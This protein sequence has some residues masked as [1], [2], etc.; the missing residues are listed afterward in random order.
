MLLIWPF[1]VLR[2]H[3]QILVWPK[4]KQPGH[5]KTQPGHR[6]TQPG[7]RKT[8]PGV[9]FALAQLCTVHLRRC[10]FGGFAKGGRPPDHQPGS[11]TY[12]PDHQPGSKTYSPDHQPG[13]KTYSPSHP[14][15][16]QFVFLSF[17]D[18]AVCLRSAVMLIFVF[19]L[20]RDGNF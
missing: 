16:C 9:E 18:P 11:K 10:G 15:D 19:C 4:K 8:Q 1:F 13:S 14:P 3:A 12:S 17:L 5:R 6:K 20:Y 2:S 7:H